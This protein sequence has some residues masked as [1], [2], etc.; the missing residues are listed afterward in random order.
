LVALA[1]AVIAATVAI[2]AWVRP[3]FWHSSSDHQ[4]A[5]AKVDVC[6][7]W[8]PV[9]KSVW[10][11]TTNPRP[12]DPVAQDA[13]AASVRLAMIGGGS[14]LKEAPAVE[15]AT[16]T[17]LTK[18]VISVANTLQWMGV[19]YLAGNQ[20]HAVLD[21]LKGKLDSEGPEIDELCK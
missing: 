17:D 15:P 4:S 13:V 20:S 1:V 8:A 2:A 10:V 18:V 19:N 11:G 14:F 3:S 6:A 9:G 21:P 16:P 7:A 12:D 5:Q